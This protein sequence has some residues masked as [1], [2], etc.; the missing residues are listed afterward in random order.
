MLQLPGNSKPKKKKK[1]DSEQVEINKWFFSKQPVTTKKK[2]KGRRYAEKKRL[3]QIK[4]R[5][6]N[7]RDNQVMQWRQR[8]HLIFI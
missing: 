4:D 3:T 7:K 5:R 2:D 6:E 8:Q 1:S